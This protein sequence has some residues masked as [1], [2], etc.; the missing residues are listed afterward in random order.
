MASNK[1]TVS[2][3]ERYD[4]N[5]MFVFTVTMGFTAFLMAWTIL[6]LAVKWWATRRRQPVRVVNAA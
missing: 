3:M 5:A 1:D 2:A 4:L 6:V